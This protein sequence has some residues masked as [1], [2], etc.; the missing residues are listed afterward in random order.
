MF[1]DNLPLELRV[2]ILS[3]RYNIR[4]KSSEIICK[5]WKKYIIADNLAIDLA[6][7][8]Q[9]DQEGYIIV[10]IPETSEILNIC[11]KI[12][13]NKIGLRFW[14]IILEKLQNGLFIEEYNGGPG[15]IYYNRTEQAYYDLLKKIKINRNL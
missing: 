14:E 11:L 15:A 8:L 6:Q 10:S 13:K 7:E 12:M 5:S 1:W 2:Y 3:I 4:N 9:V